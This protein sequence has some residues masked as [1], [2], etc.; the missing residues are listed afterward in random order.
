[1]KRY[2]KILS[3]TSLASCLLCTSCEKGLLDV[4]PPD[5]L[6]TTVFWQTEADA[7]LALTGLYNY[8]YAP[9][10]GYATS[11]YQV[12]SWDNY[13]DDAYGQYD[14]GGGTSALRSGITPNTGGYVSSY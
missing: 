12:M 13:A 1:M 10:G 4:S 6:S 5:R 8:L 3:L 7:D 11:Q 2:Q 9:G 14:Y